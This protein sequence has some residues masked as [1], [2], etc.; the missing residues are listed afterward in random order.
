MRFSLDD[1][2]GDY[3]MF[4]KTKEEANIFLNFLADH[5]RKWSSGNSYREVKSFGG[6]ADGACY[7]FN[8]GQWCSFDW[9]A[10]RGFT[11][12]EF[13]NFEWDGYASCISTDMICEFVLNL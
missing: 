11:I 7:A 10:N 12:L 8:I 1:Y 3:A 2:Q 9:Y 4:C 5:G 6:Y 13:E